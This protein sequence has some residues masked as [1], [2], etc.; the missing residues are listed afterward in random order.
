MGSV[1]IHY[2]VNRINEVYVVFLIGYRYIAIFYCKK[3]K[4]HFIA[5]CGLLYPFVSLQSNLL[6]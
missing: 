3:P 5:S 6:L 4:L 2:F 1:K